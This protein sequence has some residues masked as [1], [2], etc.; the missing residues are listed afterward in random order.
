MFRPVRLILS[1]AGCSPV[2]NLGSLVSNP[3]SL[4]QENP[5]IR[6]L[7][8]AE[9]LDRDGF[10]V[11]ENIIEEPM[12]RQLR[13]ITNALLD[14]KDEEHFKAWRSPGSMISL[15]EDPF[16]LD[17]IAH[18]KAMAAL[19]SLG[20]HSPTWATG[21]V[22][23]KPPF[24]PPL[25]WHQDW[26]GWDSPASYEPPTPLAFAFYY[27]VDTD[28][29][30]GC[31]RAI[32]GS[33]LKRHPLHESVCNADIEVLRQFSDPSHPAFS[34]VKDEV[35]IPVKAGDLVLGDSRLLHSSHGNQTDQRRTVIVIMYFPHFQGLPEPLQ[36]RIGNPHWP[37]SWPEAAR[38]KVRTLVP[39]YTGKAAPVRWNFV[40]GPEFR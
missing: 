2:E 8:H 5:P 18:P 15:T 28:R 35:E 9:K 32:P 14:K 34:T 24:S 17:L 38:D 36:A 29:A 1:R 23:S 39:A 7:S 11:F 37:D 4:L 19:R 16:F 30:N 31:L 40:P 12:L 3:V 13:A 25:F 22:I 20:W 10:C 26:W 27:L 33:H 6:F 21:Y